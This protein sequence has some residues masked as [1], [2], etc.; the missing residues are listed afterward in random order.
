MKL[1]L[2]I[3]CGKLKREG[4]GGPGR[5]VND[6]ERNGVGVQIRGQEGGRKDRRNGLG[7]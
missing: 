2:R 4:G 7:E 3:N 1:M 5:G 6:G